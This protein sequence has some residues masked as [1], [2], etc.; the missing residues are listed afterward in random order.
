MIRGMEI[1]HIILD[2]YDPSRLR[3]VFRFEGNHSNR[4]TFLRPGHLDTVLSDEGMKR[5]VIE[6][7]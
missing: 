1:R 3:L 5:W 6:T 2:Y 7:L 4:E